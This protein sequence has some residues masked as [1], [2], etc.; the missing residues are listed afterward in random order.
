MNTKK[1]L[2]LA[3]S[4]TMLL[5]SNAY[6]QFPSMVPAPQNIWQP[7]PQFQPK[8]ERTHRWYALENEQN[9]EYWQNVDVS[10]LIICLKKGEHEQA[11]QEL[12]AKYNLQVTGSNSMFPEVINFFGFSVPNSSKQKVL[13]II[14]DAH[15]IAAIEYAEPE[16]IIE[17]QMCY[18]DD[19][20]NYPN[21]G[22]EQWGNH[23]FWIDSAWC[24]AYKGG[25]GQWVGV[26]D[27]ALDYTHPDIGV[28]YENDFAD[29]DSDVKPDWT[30][31]QYH[32]THVTGII[33]GKTNNGIGIAGVCN[34]T[35]FFIK[36][37]KDGATTFD[38]AIVASAIM[39]MANQ[40][41]VR[42]INMSFGSTSS[43]ASIEAACNYAWSQNKLL[44]AASGNNGKEET[45][46]PANYNTVMA[47]GSVGYDLSTTSFV[48]SSSFSNYGSKQE[49]SAAGGNGD[50]GPYDIWSTL[51]SNKYGRLSGTSMAA[52]MVAGVAALMFDVNP[53]LSNADARILL[54]QNVFDAGPIGRDKYYGYGI[55]CGWCAVN[56]AKEFKT[57]ITPHAALQSIN[58]NDFLMKLYPNPSEG[59]INIEL[60]GNG[61]DT[62]VL[63][64]NA[65]GE[66]VWSDNIE[67]PQ[68]VNADLSKYP[69]GIY[70]AIAK[71]DGKE[72]IERF[73]II[74]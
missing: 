4:A 66:R 42:V 64:F 41:K 56:A 12:V 68:T 71:Y 10:K 15:K 19:P 63:I 54:Q 62:K 44:I 72:E 7:A 46:Y 2:L 34:D 53:S 73:S 20:Y 30:G 17:T 13:Q 6:A 55:V 49:I 52:P 74:K 9:A 32:G 23:A 70:F 57:P 3:V 58:K 29:G 43:D 47:V 18:S 61:V 50:G 14:K 48:F 36:A 25:W 69:S 31:K 16:S 1:N 26:I 40:P 21:T 59:K 27:N 33:G 24:I 45:L 22:W 5:A 65:I 51:P 28:V 35:V 11:I 67:A 60:T 38:N 8:L 39:E 37:V